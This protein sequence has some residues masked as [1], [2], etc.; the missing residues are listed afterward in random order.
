MPCAGLAA[1]SD[2]DFADVVLMGRQMH[3][4]CQRLLSTVKTG[5]FAPL[6]YLHCADL[7]AAN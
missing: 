2:A 6:N 5:S 3:Q 1:V 4:K 7:L